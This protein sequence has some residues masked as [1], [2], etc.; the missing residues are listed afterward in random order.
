MPRS[1][2]TLDWLEDSDRARP[3]S[4]TGRD[5]GRA[6]AARISGR[7]AS[8][9]A[10]ACRWSASEQPS[11]YARG[12]QQAGRYSH[13]TLL[14]ALS[15]GS[16]PAASFR[17]DT[18]VIDGP[19]FAGPT[20]ARPLALTLT[21]AIR[22]RPRYRRTPTCPVA[23]GGCW[24]APPHQHLPR[25]PLPIASRPIGAAPGQA[26]WFLGRPLLPSPSGLPP[27]R[28]TRACARRPLANGCRSP[29]AHF[30]PCLALSGTPTRDRCP[31]GCRLTRRHGLGPRRLYR[32]R[33]LA[34]RRTPDAP[35]G[36]P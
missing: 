7:R 33:T 8:R 35:P 10:R 1:D 11:R 31:R 6:S 5:R 15:A 32:L 13:D 14:S 36:S 26:P 22:G 3:A 19:P 23:S 2:P 34:D 12:S 9:V 24:C 25:G 18:P 28:D 30:A 29:Q 17:G 21:R 16:W 4:E 20:C 27:C